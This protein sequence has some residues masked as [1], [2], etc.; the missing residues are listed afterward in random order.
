MSTTEPNGATIQWRLATLEK[1]IEGKA[2]ND[3]L[4]RLWREL[5]GIRR[6]LTSLLISLLV[7]VLGAMFTLLQL[8]HP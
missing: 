6:L 8:G 1:Q 5:A 3:D 7:V 4:E 2:D